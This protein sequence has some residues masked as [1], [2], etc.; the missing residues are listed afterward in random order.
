VTKRYEGAG[1]PAVD[2]VSLEVA[3][4][5]AVAVMGPSGSG[6]STLLNLIAGMD[7][8]S[9]GQVTGERVDDMSETG[10]AR[11]RRR[12]IGISFSS[13]TCWRT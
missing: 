7:K 3:A 5:E 6:K 4:G 13:S 9:G 12:E 11:F 2:D 10:V 1:H 8:P